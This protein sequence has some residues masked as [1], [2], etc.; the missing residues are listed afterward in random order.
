M[1][2]R[3]YFC[4]FRGAIGALPL[5][6]ELATAFKAGDRCAIDLLSVEKGAISGSRSIV[7]FWPEWLPGLSTAISLPKSFLPSRRYA[8]SPSYGDLRLWPLW[9][10]V[11]AD[12]C[13]EKVIDSLA[14]EKF[15]NPGKGTSALPST[16]ATGYSM[17]GQES[18]P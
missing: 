12:P 16:A 3:N 15:R 4:Q 13:F 7:C 10:P 14:R 11:W 1:P 6:S 2:T 5:Q 8:G 18:I 17:A 9:D